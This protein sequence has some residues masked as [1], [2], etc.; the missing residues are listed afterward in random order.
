MWGQQVRE[1]RFLT[2]AF[3]TGGSADAHNRKTMD[4]WTQCMCKSVT[5]KLN[6]VKAKKAVQCGTEMS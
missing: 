3:L 5:E 2:Q 6:G 1:L 4:E